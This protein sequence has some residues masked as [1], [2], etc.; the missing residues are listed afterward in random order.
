MMKNAFLVEKSYRYIAKSEL[1]EIGIA[2]DEC[3]L[4]KVSWIAFY[5]KQ[6]VLP[7]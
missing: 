6:L 5:F 7:V 2:Y 4:L 3:G 1:G